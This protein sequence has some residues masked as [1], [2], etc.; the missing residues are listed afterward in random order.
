MTC[1][2]YECIGHEMCINFLLQ[3]LSITFF[4]VNNIE[5]A[6]LDMQA[7]LDKSLHIK[8]LLQMTDIN[9]NLN[10]KTIFHFQILSCIEMGEESK[11]NR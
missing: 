11:S 8:C 6:A 9:E 3:H 2:L 10:D 7:E 4:P 1:N 5:H